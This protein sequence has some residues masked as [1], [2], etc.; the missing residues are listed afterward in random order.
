[1]KQAAVSINLPVIVPESPVLT[2]SDS[3]TNSIDIPQKPS[4]VIKVTNDEVGVV[5]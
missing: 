1:M 5:S 4:T 2:S 3:E